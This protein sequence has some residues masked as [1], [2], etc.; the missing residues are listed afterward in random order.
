MWVDKHRSLMILDLRLLEEPHKCPASTR[1]HRKA[2]RCF[3]MNLI[4]LL[5]DG[6]ASFVLNLDLL[7]VFF[8]HVE[9]QDST[10]KSKEQHPT[11]WAWKKVGC[12][13]LGRGNSRERGRTW[14][15]RERGL[16]RGQGAWNLRCLDL[17]VR[18]S[19]NRH[20]S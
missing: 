6:P 8:L 12:P 2:L 17:S 4:F 16:R 5:Q 18:G 14:K 1:V 9:T 13:I 15:R 19:L 10:L 20:K 7:L 11:L 3:L